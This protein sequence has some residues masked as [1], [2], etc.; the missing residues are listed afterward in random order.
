VK[1]GEVNS[2]LS[3]LNIVACVML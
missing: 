3:L 1:L 2:I